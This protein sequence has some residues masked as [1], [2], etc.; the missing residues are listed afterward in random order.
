MHARAGPSLAGRGCAGHSCNKIGRTP[1]KQ[2][3]P[4]APGSQRGKHVQAGWLELARARYASVAEGPYSVASSARRCARTG[5]LE[6]PG[7]QAEFG[8]TGP[9]GSEVTLNRPCTASSAAQRRQQQRHQPNHQHRTTTQQNQQQP[10][11]ATAATV[12]M[13][14]RRTH[15][16]YIKNTCTPCARRGAPKACMHR[17]MQA[18]IHDNKGIMRQ[19]IL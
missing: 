17:D 15:Q 3:W 18:C 1:G 16:I 8:L 19:A 9:A 12:H 13:Q 11:T 5:G 6:P 2:P 7:V 4:E 10:A 14:E